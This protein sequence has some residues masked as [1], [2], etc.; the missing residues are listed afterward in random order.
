[1]FRIATIGLISLIALTPA[2]GLTTVARAAESVDVI[3]QASSNSGSFTTVD[4][5][6]AGGFRIVSEGGKRYLELADDFRTGRGP[7]LFVL[8]HNEAVPSSYNANNYINLGRLE[9][10]SGAQRYEIPA[11]ADLSNFASV[12][13]WC[14]QF[15]VTFGYAPLA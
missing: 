8:L 11:D 3:A 10:F 15:D 7:D 6:T 5:N 1:M 12:V 14:R 13:I 2:A 4:K 9:K